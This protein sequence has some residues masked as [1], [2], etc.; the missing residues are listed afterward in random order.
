M[1]ELLP[2]LAVALSIAALILNALT[3]LR[4][5]R[6]RETD[7]AKALVGRVAEVEGGVTALA[8]TG[9]AIAAVAGRVNETESRL[10]KLETLV[11][12]MATKEDVTALRGEV[13]AVCQLVDNQ[14][15]PG[16]RRIE[17]YMLGHA[18]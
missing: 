3:F 17:D 18:K 9:E 13:R 1:R 7:D 10:D 14:V 2:Y 16:I 5:G 4:G 11:A 8:G 15:V 6:W 12:S